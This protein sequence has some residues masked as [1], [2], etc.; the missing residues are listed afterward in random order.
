MISTTDNTRTVTRSTK[1][2]LKSLEG[3]KVIK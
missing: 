1:Y 2:D 3:R